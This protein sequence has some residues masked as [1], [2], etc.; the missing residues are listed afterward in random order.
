MLNNCYATLYCNDMC[1]A[2]DTW[3]VH[4]CILFPVVSYSGKLFR[5]FLVTAILNYS[6]DDLLVDGLCVYVGE[7]TWVRACVRTCV[8]AWV[9]V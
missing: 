3:F 4:I 6:K 7:N 2:V 8:R 1:W 9:R 5:S